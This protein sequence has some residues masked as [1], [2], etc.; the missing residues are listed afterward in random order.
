MGNTIVMTNNAS[1]IQFIC[2]DTHR[3]EG[4]SYQQITPR[5]RIGYEV[6]R[7]ERNWEG[8]RQILPCWYVW[9]D[10]RKT[11]SRK[12]VLLKLFFLATAFY[13]LLPDIQLTRSVEGELAEKLQKCFSPGV[14]TLVEK[15]GKIKI[16]N[17]QWTDN[18]HSWSQI[19]TLL[20]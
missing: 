18:G 20:L 16:C 17:Y 13:R 14:I 8:P 2:L 5:T 9:T 11:W 12:Y 19:F 7:G 15:N 4:S 6:A 10:E 3:K 1:W